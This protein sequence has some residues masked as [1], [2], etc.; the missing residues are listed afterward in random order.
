MGWQD[1]HPILG[2]VREL[3]GTADD[4]GGG[5]GSCLD[6]GEC[7]STEFVDL[8]TGKEIDGAYLKCGDCGYV[9]IREGDATCSGCGKIRTQE[10]DDVFN[11]DHDAQFSGQ[12]GDNASL[13]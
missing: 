8:E 1:Y 5:G 9:P 4:G 10:D 13:N 11:E 6:G 7:G 12:C 3:N 2:P